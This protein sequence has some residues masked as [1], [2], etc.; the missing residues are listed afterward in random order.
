MAKTRRGKRVARRRAPAK[1][2][3]S[4]GT[5]RGKRS[6]GSRLIN[7]PYSYVFKPDTQW[8]ISTPLSGT[9]QVTGNAVAPLS[10]V[11]LSSIGGSASLFTSYYDFGWALSFTLRD[12]Q[13]ASD[14]QQ[15]YDQYRINWIDIKVTYLSQGA[16]IT[17]VG[18]LPTVYAVLDNDNAAVP[19]DARTV[20]SKQGSKTFRISDA[21][22]SF[23]MRC[24][25]KASI[26]VDSTTGGQQALQAPRGWLDC[27]QDNILHFGAKF[28]ADNV[29]LPAGTS[30]NTGIQLDYV[31]NVS[32]RGA[33]NL[34]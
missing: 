18:V 21:R 2:G 14:F 7:K 32:F 19:G 34:Y 24:K 6:T 11:S 17:G 16:N 10:V 26:V 20:R 5:R 30:T 9:L 31:Y 27:N 1:R 12:L 23:M 3:P 8:M 29:Y 33:Q 13:N 25:P 22:N 28:W 15:I 4:A